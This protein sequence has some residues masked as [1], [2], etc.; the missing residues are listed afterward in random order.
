VKT[1]GRVEVFAENGYKIEML[2]EVPRVPSPDVTINGVKADLKRITSHNNVVRE[3]KSAIR[4][5]GAEAVLFE[6]K[7]ETDEIHNELL[8]L[9]KYDIHG[10]Y[11]F[12]NNHDK[13]Y[14]F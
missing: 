4:K 3:A 6:F 5:Q 12:S 10:Y 2:K 9:K 13:I 14:S 8:Q 11:Y 1:T 7:K